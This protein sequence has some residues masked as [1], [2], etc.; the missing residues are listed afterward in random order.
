MEV[1]EPEPQSVPESKNSKKK[2]KKENDKENTKKEKETK[3]RKLNE[4]M[5]G[6]DDDE[7]IL[8]KTKFD[9]DE[10]ITL[11]LS[12]GEEMKLNKRKKSAY[13]SSLPSTRVRNTH[14]T[15]AEVGAKFDKNIKKKKYKFLED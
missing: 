5:E 7:P 1:P 9:W 15:P 13:P 4:S 3:K 11:L 12:K 10:T 6:D 14:K 2:R 8:K